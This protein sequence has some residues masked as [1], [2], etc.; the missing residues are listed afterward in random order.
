ML[1][2][3][4]RTWLVDNREGMRWTVVEGSRDLEKL[5][6]GIVG[7]DWKVCTSEPTRSSILSHLTQGDSDSRIVAK[8]DRAISHFFPAFFPAWIALA[9]SVDRDGRHGRRADLG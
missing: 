5:V 7:M 3:S 8:H 2:R 4:G 6:K 1:I 9:V